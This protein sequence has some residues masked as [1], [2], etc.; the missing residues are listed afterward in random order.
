MDPHSSRVALDNIQIVD[1]FRP[2]IQAK[3][4]HSYRSYHSSKADV[5]RYQI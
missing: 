2:Q 1:A 5:Y 3:L 4:T